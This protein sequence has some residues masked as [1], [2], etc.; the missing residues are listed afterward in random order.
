MSR[1]RHSHTATL[2]PSG[3][4][5]VA[6]GKAG[7]YWA[8]AE[9]YDPSTRSWIA[10]G[11]MADARDQHTATLLPDGRVLVTGGFT[12]GLAVLASAELYDPATGTWTPTGS[13]ILPRYGHT[14]TLLP[15]GTV[16]VAGGGTESEGGG[17][18][19]AAE[20]YHPDTGTWTPAGDMSTGRNN[21]TATPLPDGTVLVA[22]GYDFGTVDAAEIY[23]PT[24]G[25]WRPAGTMDE[26][27][28][29]HMATLLE[30]GSVLVIGGIGSFYSLTTAELYKPRR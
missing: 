13:M 24:S 19:E 29:E 18:P 9:L 15:D 12:T 28:F 3:L 4:V 30:N 25:N 20:I 5:L 6:G 23:R 10:T 2:L 21:A 1:V 14:A 17:P 16:L 22:G 8:E 7:E 27:R 11:T 26:P